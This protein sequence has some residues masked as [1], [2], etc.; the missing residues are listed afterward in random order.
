MSIPLH[1]L[2]IYQRPALGGAFITRKRVYNYQHQILA[3]G[4]FDTASCDITVTPVEGNMALENWTGCRVA[5]FVDNPVEPI[6]EGLIIRLTYGNFTIGLDE[7][8]NRVHV[9]KNM[10]NNALGA[11]N[12][13]GTA[14]NNTASQAIF[15]IKIG[16]LDGLTEHRAAFGAGE[17]ALRDRTLAFQAWPKASLVPG[18]TPPSIM[19][20]EMA[21]FY[22]TLEWERFNS[23]S[24]VG[25][26][27]SVHVTDLVG[28]LVNGATFFDNTDTSLVTTNTDFQRVPKSRQGTT[29]WQQLQMIQEMGDASGNRWVMGITPTDPVEGRRFYYRQANLAIEYTALA[30]DNFRLRTQWG[31]LVRPWTVRPDRKV[32]VN[33]LLIGWNSQGDDPRETYIDAIT[34]DAERQTV[35]W[36]GDDDVSTE[37]VFQLRKVYKRHNSRFGHPIRDITI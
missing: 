4:G 22:H 10:A 29:F 11:Q 36:Q 19:H 17:D 24:T 20:V 37:G 5:V 33:D 7:M 26:N 9:T 35:Q 14:A 25:V 18:Q 3:V 8:M 27:A 30:R 32:R 28:A 13:A 34:Y 31:G 2:S 1:Y 6:W 15:G 23:A 16:T 12:L 21:G